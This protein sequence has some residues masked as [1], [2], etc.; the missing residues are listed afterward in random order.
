MELPTSPEIIISCEHAGNQIPEQ[1]QSLFDGAEE[2]LNSHRGWDAGAL[3]LAETFSKKTGLSLFSYSYSRL[4]IDSNRSIGHPKLFSE[5][6]RPLPTPEKQKII[7]KFYLPYRNHVTDE[8]KK[9]IERNDKILHI[10]VHSFT[11]KL[12]HKERNF[13]LGLLYDPSRML[14]RNTCQLWKFIIKESFPEFRIRMNQPYK[15]ISD[16]FTT[17]LRKTFDPNSYLGIELEVNQKL[18][19][20]NKADWINICSK[21]ADTFLHLEKNLE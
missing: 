20:K 19:L 21:L 4:L 10:G 6:T 14:E 15:G 2:I 17:S 9:K 3:Q 7:E 12:N 8:I 11:P 13:E 18:I 16:G 1:Y 5:F